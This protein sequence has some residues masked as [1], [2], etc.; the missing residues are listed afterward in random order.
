MAD[1]IR[2]PIYESGS[3]IILVYCRISTWLIDILGFL[4]YKNTLSVTSEITYMAFSSASAIGQ[5]TRNAYIY[6]NTVCLHTD[7]VKHTHSTI[8]I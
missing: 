2:K 7:A 6:T 4:E 8:C 3:N 1:N 5:W